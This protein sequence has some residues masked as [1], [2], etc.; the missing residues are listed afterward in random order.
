MLV[1]LNHYLTRTDN[2]AQDFLRRALE[3]AK[4]SFAEYAVFHTPGSCR[5]L[6]NGR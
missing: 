4:A 6:I 1:Q 5:R 3:K 2:Y